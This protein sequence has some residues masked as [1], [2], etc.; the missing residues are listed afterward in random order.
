M[1]DNPSLLTPHSAALSE[2]AVCRMAYRAAQNIL[3]H[4]KGRLAPEFVFEG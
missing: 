4:F 1:A 2:E 3:D